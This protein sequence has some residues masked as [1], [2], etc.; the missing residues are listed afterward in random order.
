MLL[1][2]NQSAQSSHPC[3]RIERLE[4]LRE[5]AERSHHLQPM[6]RGS[7]RNEIS[8]LP[9]PTNFT[10]CAYEAKYV[11]SCTCRSSYLTV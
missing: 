1:T 6:G 10:L 2:P 7:E 9:Y 4:L 11:G 5:P 3:E 8:E